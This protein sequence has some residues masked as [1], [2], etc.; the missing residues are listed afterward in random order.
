MDRKTLEMEVSKL[1]PELDWIQDEKL[2]NATLR[3]GVTLWS[4]AAGSPRI[5]MKIP[6]TLLLDPCPA[7]FLTHTRSVTTI[8]YT[9]GKTIQKFYDEKTLPV[10]VDYLVSG[11]ILHD[12][13][14]LMEYEKKDGKVVKSPNGKMLRHP[15]SGVAIGFDKGLPDE[16]LHMIAMHAKEGNLGKRI[17][18]AV[19]IH[20]ADFMNFESFH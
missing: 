5:L 6:F 10:N 18:E 12:V 20:H 1:I 11:A 19:L 7:S 8:A 9:S 14:K 2:R 3:V 16:V 15:Y 17:P 4:S 13:G